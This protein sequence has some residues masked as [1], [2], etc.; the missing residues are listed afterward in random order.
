MRVKISVGLSEQMSRYDS[1]EGN[2]LAR[3]EAVWCSWFDVAR[4]HIFGFLSS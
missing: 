3:F 1:R 2:A 4:S